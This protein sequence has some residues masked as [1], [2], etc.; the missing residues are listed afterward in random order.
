[1]QI[2]LGA[3]SYAQCPIHIALCRL[4]YAHRTI[5]IVLYNLHYVN[6]TM[7]ITMHNSLCT[8]HYSLYT[9]CIIMY[10]SL[11]KCL[12]LPKYFGD[13]HTITQSD[14]VNSRANFCIQKCLDFRKYYFF[15]IFVLGL[16]V[17]KFF[18]MGIACVR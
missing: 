6:C 10:I 12:G 7:H 14:F 11:C 13:K 17:P 18:P 9:M 15:L 8:L 2:S 3:Y 5:H 16:L 4:H 1:M